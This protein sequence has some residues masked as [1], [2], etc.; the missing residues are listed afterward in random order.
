MFR[1]VYHVYLLKGPLKWDI[2]LTTFFGFRKFKHAS[3]MRVILF[4]KT[5]KIES[6]DRKCKKR[7]W[8][9]FTFLNNWIWK[10]CNKLPPLRREYLSS[11]VNGLTNSPNIVS[12]RLRWN[13]LMEP[14]KQDFLGVY[15]TIFFGVH[16][17]K[18]TSALRV[19][20][21]WKMFK[22][23]SK[24]RKFKGDIEKSFW[25]WRCCCELYLLRR[26]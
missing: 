17:F 26:K 9:F 7:L 8:K 1:P 14:L 19:I 6:K 13:L 18:N 5:L 15:L 10:C 24:F 22:I 21:F 23:E 20:F 12:A 4:F 2:Y 11:A 3:P 16:K 25:I